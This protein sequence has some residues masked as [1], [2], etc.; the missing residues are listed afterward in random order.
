MWNVKLIAAPVVYTRPRCRRR[1]FVLLSLSFE[2]EVDAGPAMLPAVPTPKVP[3][4][5]PAF[6][7][8]LAGTQI[9]Q[10]FFCF[11]PKLSS[12]VRNH[13]LNRIVRGGFTLR[14]RY[15]AVPFFDVN[16]Y[17]HSCHLV[18][19]HVSSVSLVELRFVMIKS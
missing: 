1:E 10:D 6:E 5:L 14:G 17:P 18:T 4:A 3:D 8:L 9:Q 2:M 13:Q 19:K 16:L 7:P 11:Q 15:N 12:S